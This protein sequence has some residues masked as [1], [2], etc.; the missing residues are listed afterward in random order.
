MPRKRDFR[1][2]K[3]LNVVTFKGEKATR[4]SKFSVPIRYAAQILI[5]TT[6]V[7]AG[8]SLSKCSGFSP[9]QED[10]PY[11]DEYHGFRTNKRS[12][13]KKV[14]LKRKSKAYHV[15]KA[16]LASSWLNAREHL[17]LAL[18]TRQALP[19]GQ[20][21]VIPSCEEEACGRC[22]YCSPGQFLCAD[23]NN[24]VHAGGRSLH[25]PEVWKVSWRFISHSH[26]FNYV[27]KPDSICTLAVGQFR[28]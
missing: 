21:C 7:A 11:I 8:S 14:R 12:K 18:L 24:L 19:L 22:L 6:P 4:K 27:V 5:D 10:L 25:H 26:L 13:N 9:E 16:T 17:V 20:V 1:S 15:R 3:S 28:L 2:K 23:H